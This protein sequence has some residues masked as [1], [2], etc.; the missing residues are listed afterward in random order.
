MKQNIEHIQMYVSRCREYAWRWEQKSWK[1][2][3]IVMKKDSKGFSFDLTLAER[4]LDEFVLVEGGWKKDHCAICH[5]ELFD[6]D[7][8]S[9]GT[10][11][12]NGRD[13][14][15]TECHQRFIAENFFAS[16]YTD[17]T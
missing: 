4:W 12:T 14:V 7:D 15:C 11:F 8:A 5:W 6:S 1:A 2:R 9:H 16:P 3:D 13:W 10:G 17:L